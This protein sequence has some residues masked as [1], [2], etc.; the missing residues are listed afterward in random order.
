MIP[1]C[2]ARRN[3]KLQSG[4]ARRFGQRFDAPVVNITS[5]VEDDLDH[6]FVFGPLGDHSSHRFRGVNVP[7]LA[8]AGGLLD[9]RSGADRLAFIV[10]DQLSVYVI[11][12]AEDRE[13]R[14]GVGSPDLLAN[15]RVNRA[16]HILS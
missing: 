2:G 3:L 14:T 8:H 16:P 15:A 10:I 4:F 5:A 1:L 12:A 9:S 11:D 6:A 7:A 13:P